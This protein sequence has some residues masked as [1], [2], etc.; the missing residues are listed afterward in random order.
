MC[1]LYASTCACYSVAMARNDP[2][3][4]FRIPLTL[5]ARLEQATAASGKSL[6]AEVV[7]RLESS[8]SLS[9][10]H[11]KLSL[12]FETLLASHKIMQQVLQSQMD[13]LTILVRELDWA[14]GRILENSACNS[15]APTNATST[16]AERVSH[17]AAAIS[18]IAARAVQSPQ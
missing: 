9:D 18:D 16:I 15:D 14:H 11:E 1:F 3:I 2:Q 7:G 10:A 4:N 13:I 5:R 17:A 12:D 6:T 8:F